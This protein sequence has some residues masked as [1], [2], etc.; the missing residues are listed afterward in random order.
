MYDN[1]NVLFKNIYIDLSQQN[2]RVSFVYMMYH[3][4]YL[5]RICEITKLAFPH[6]QSV[7]IVSRVT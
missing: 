5:T 4:D 6:R 7:M 1:D 3:Y 2:Q